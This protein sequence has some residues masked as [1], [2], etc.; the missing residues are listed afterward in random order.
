MEVVCFHASGWN[1]AFGDAVGSILVALTELAD[2][3]PMDRGAT[4]C[5]HGSWC[6]NEEWCFSPIVLHVIINVDHDVVTPV[7]REGGPRKLICDVLVLATEVQRT[8]ILTV[9]EHRRL[10]DAIRPEPV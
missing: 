9:D 10:P 1:G 6:G 5:Q 4:P 2:A 3:V 8:G 7:R